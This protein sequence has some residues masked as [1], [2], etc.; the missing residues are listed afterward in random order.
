MAS[1][2]EAPVH[3]VKLKTEPFYGLTP[4]TFMVIQCVSVKRRTRLLDAVLVCVK[5]VE[6]HHTDKRHDKKG[7]DENQRAPN[8]PFLPARHNADRTPKNAGLPERRI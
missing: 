5:N 4:F 6:N 8:H 1:L 7:R 2:Y 3:Y